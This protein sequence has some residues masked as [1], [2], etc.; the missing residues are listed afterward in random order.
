MMEETE[1]PEKTPRSLVEMDWNSIP[2]TMIAE[3][4]GVVHNHYAS[5]TT[6]LEPFF[7]FKTT[8]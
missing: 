2:H 8:V 1:Y 6:K 3:G 7:F 4:G 5:L